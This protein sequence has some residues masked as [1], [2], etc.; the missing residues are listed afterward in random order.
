MNKTFR[1]LQEIFGHSLKE[2]EPLAQ[3]TTLKVGGPA[4]YFLTSPTSGEL[5]QAII[6]ARKIG[7][8]YFVLG[9]GSNILIA[10]SGIQGL[11][12]RNTSKKI[13]IRGAHG[14]HS[15]GEVTK[16]E[17]FVEADCG[18]PMNQLVR[19]TVEEGLGGLEA[20]L[21][22]PGSV[23]GA[24]YMNSKWMHPESYVG[25]CLF[26]AT[27]LTPAGEVVTVPHSYFRFGYDYSILHESGDILLSAV[28]VLKPTQKDILWDIAN[29]SIEYRRK[30]QPQ[31]VKTAGCTFRNISKADAISFSTPDL[32]TSAGF[33]I[34]H[35]GLKG[36]K[37]GGAQISD[38][39]ANFIVNTGNAKANDVLELI[40]KAK[41]E[42]KRVFGVSLTEEIVIVQ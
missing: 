30:S 4:E 42:V 32:T 28:F 12:I 7:M 36:I 2:N 21:G 29:K 18:V 11:V 17:V 10:D 37:I 3:Y 25:D 24:V 14:V 33:L 16:G 38:M 1:E 20:H 8:K 13:S 15:N 31:G 27:I 34:D 23:G 22:L 41:S 39:H 40:Q 35:A 6:F 9:G 26:Q 19:F 5:A